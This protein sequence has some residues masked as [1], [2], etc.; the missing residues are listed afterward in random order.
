MP[1]FEAL[2][3]LNSRPGAGTAAG[4]G[5]FLFIAAKTAIFG[6]QEAAEA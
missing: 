3:G 6:E 1:R 5:G 2:G 4:K